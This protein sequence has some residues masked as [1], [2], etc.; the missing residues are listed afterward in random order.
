MTRFDRVFSPRA[1]YNGLQVSR[2]ENREDYRMSSQVVCAS[3]ADRIDNAKTLNAGM[4]GAGRMGNTHRAFLGGPEGGLSVRYL[5]ET[6]G[7]SFDHN[8]KGAAQ[9][10][11]TPDL[12]VQAGLR[13]LLTEHR[14][15]SSTGADSVTQSASRIGFRKDSISSK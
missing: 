4:V 13:A 11:K 2:D 10:R 12:S 7:P 15:R 3:Q 5:A 9:D 14:E 1:F 8:E 6:N